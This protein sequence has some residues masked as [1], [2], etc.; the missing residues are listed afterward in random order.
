MLLK[1]RPTDHSQTIFTTLLEEGSPRI[2]SLATLPTV[3]SVS[4]AWSPGKNT[5]TVLEVK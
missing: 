4:R 3:I 5:K 1:L 2:V